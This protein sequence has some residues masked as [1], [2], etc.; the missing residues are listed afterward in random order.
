MQN[1]EDVMNELKKMC[2]KNGKVKKTDIDKTLKQFGFPL[3]A[4]KT[5]N[6]IYLDC[7]V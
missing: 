7:K 1:K 4:L 2:E 5:R 6:G 3:S